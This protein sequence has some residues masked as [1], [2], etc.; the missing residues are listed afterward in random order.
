VGLDRLLEQGQSD[1]LSDLRERIVDVVRGGLTELDEAVQ[2]ASGDRSRF[3]VDCKKAL[4]RGS[5]LEMAG[6]A[7]VELVDELSIGFDAVGG[8]TMGADALAHAV[9]MLTNTDWFSVRK[10]EKNRGTRKRIEGAELGKGRRVLLV[11]DVVTR[12]GS[13]FDALA[14]IRAT[15]AEVVAAVTLVDRGTDGVEKFEREGIPYGALVTYGQL[16]IPPVGSE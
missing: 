16:G 8:L 13:I 7:L 1:A 10:I 2:L 12:G 3:F 15:G 14:A 9:A 5:D 4:A 6:Q 11:D